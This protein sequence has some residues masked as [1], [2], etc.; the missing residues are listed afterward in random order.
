ML[1]LFDIHAQARFPA[2]SSKFT[3]LDI[4]RKIEKD[5][6][7][8]LLFHDFVDVGLWEMVCPINQ[9]AYAIF[10]HLLGSQS[11]KALCHT[12]KLILEAWEKDDFYSTAEGVEQQGSDLSTSRQSS[13]L[14][15]I[16]EL[17]PNRLFL[18]KHCDSTNGLPKEIRQY[19]LNLLCENPFDLDSQQI[20][21]LW[22]KF[23]TSSDLS[24][25]AVK[26][27]IAKCGKHS[28]DEKLRF[29]N[30]RIAM[31]IYEL[32]D[33]HPG[34]LV[35]PFRGTDL[36]D[37]L[38]R[39][40]S[41]SKT[42]T[43]LQSPHFLETFLTLFLD[44][45]FHIRLGSLSPE[46]II[47]LHESNFW[48]VFLEDFHQMARSISETLSHMDEAG[49]QEYAREEFSTVLSLR[50]SREAALFEMIQ[51]TL[52]SL[53]NFS[54]FSSSQTA[55]QWLERYKKRFHL[56]IAHPA[57]YRFLT[58]LEKKLSSNQRA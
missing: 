6:K 7:I 57:L 39:I 27:F 37:S 24:W 21:L 11:F 18:Y 58:W 29:Y 35:V 13:L 5:I 48:R 1:P 56:S 42:V 44:S 38:L 45:K 47:E 22:S 10:K 52:F 19:A 54:S 15:H 36:G 25:P 30:N 2:F 20:D 3:Q 12:R 23:P 51:I 32:G 53:L 43:F 41:I 8:A 14:S 28:N 17:D 26:S 34:R 9:R 40:S 55:Q 46:A 33:S 49:I 50:A 16:R 31:S 4:C